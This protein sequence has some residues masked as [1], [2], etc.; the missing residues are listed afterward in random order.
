VKI[1]LFQMDSVLELNTKNLG[2]Y[3]SFLTISHMTP[4]AKQFRSYGI[5]KFDFAVEFCF[6]TEQRLNRSQLLGL[7]LTETLEVPNT[8]MVGNSLSFTTVH[9]MAR[10][11]WRFMSYDYRK[12][13]RSTETEIWADYT[14]RHKS[15]VWQKKSMTS[16]ETLYTKNGINKLSFPLVTHTSYSDARFDSYGVL[17]SGQSSE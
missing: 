5:S 12:L 9:N 8:I 14:S 7:G 3:P 11:G 6:R 13:D 10:I 4:S 17:K 16:L 1:E 15:G 2:N